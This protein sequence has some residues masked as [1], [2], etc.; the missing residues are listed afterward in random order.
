MSEILPDLDVQK[1][2][3]AALCV[4]NAMNSEARSVCGRRKTDAVTSKETCSQCSRS[5]P[6]TVCDSENVMPSSQD[7]SDCST[8]LMDETLNS[9]FSP[10]QL[11]STYTNDHDDSIT[12]AKTPARAPRPLGLTK[13]L[14]RLTKRLQ[15]HPGGDHQPIKQKRLTPKTTNTV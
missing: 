3:S 9:T 14:H 2:E 12:I 6:D 4:S 13:T 15:E 1:V 11:D 10:L 7:S 5:D 8:L